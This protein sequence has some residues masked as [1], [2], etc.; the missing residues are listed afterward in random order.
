[1]ASANHFFH[2]KTPFP[3]NLPD[4]R[5]PACEAL[6]RDTEM[7]ARKLAAETERA[8]A[9]KQMA[10]AQQ[11]EHDRLLRLIFSSDQKET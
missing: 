4:H 5:C 1:M 6:Y 9:M 8:E 2:P 10:L 3:G 7:W 11:A